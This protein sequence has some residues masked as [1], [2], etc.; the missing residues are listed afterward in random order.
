MPGNVIRVGKHRSTLM[1]FGLGPLVWLA[2]GRDV[3]MGATGGSWLAWIVW[4]D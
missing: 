3:R 2:L 1:R 4:A